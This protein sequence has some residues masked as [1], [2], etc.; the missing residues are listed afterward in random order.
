MSVNQFLRLCKIRS[1]FIIYASLIFFVAGCAV[2]PNAYTL[3]KNPSFDDNHFKNSKA[4]I[5]FTGNV[6]LE[7][8]KK[9][10]KRLFPKN[11]FSKKICQI[12]QENF[13]N[14][15]LIVD[16]EIYSGKL[17]EFFSGTSTL[18]SNDIKNAKLFLNKQKNPYFIL[19]KSV[20]IQKGNENISI[21][22]NEIFKLCKSTIKKISSSSGL[23]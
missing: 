9:S 6:L 8:Y 1:G 2:R 17:P 10:F 16:G 11:T 22:T 23:D 19:I 14:N 5:G 4:T 18:N 13:I 20:K 12:I 3:V 21:L 15:H 7:N